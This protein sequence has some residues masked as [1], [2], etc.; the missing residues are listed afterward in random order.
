[1]TDIRPTEH[2]FLTP[3]NNQSL[4]SVS[5]HLDCNLRALERLCSVSIHNRGH[6]FYVFGSQKGSSSA[7][8]ALEHFYH[9]KRSIPYTIEELKHFLHASPVADRSRPLARE[10]TATPLHSVTTPVGQVVLKNQKQIAY[11]AAMERS[12]LTFGVGYAG[13][14]KTFLAIAYAAHAYYTGKVERIVLVRPAVEAGEKLGF[15]PG[16]ISEKTHPYFTPLYDALFS[17]IGKQMVRELEVANIIEIAPLAYMRGRTLKNAC[18]ILDEAQNTT[19]EQMKMFLTRLGPGSTMVI[20]GDESQLDVP[21]TRSGLG[22]ALRLLEPLTKT[23]SISVVRFGLAEV[24]RHPLVTAILHAY[25][26]ER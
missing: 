11:H 14:G 6:E 2:F 15:L 23:E 16:D 1:M 9:Q 25:D 20:T 24:M 8:Q 3:E 10:E 22:H 19:R 18:I 21:Q 4:L 26:Q 7:R 17:T 12:V 13:T 5:G